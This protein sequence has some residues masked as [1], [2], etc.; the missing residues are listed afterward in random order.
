MTMNAAAIRGTC[1]SCGRYVATYARK[2]STARLACAHK[3]WLRDSLFG[4]PGE[5]VACTGSNQSV[6]A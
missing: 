2:D 3:R 4:E 6:K 5:W 1:V